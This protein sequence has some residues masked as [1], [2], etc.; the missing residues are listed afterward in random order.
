MDRGGKLRG[1]L[2]KS[3]AG[4]TIASTR[5]VTDNE[6]HHVMLSG[7]SGGQFLYLDGEFIGSLS[8]AIKPIPLSHAYLGGGYVTTPWDGQLAGTKYFAGQIDEAALYTTALGHGS[9]AQNYR[10]RTGLVSGDA[11]TTADPSSATPLPPSGAWTNRRA[12]P[13]PPASS[14]PTA[15]PARTRTPPW[16][17]P[18]SSASTTAPRRSSPAPDRSPCRAT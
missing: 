6:W 2:D 3:Q 16:A 7:Y 15:P 17:P 9:A 14:P 10:A 5:V 1:Q 12:R 8:G 18:A 11:R 4:T 13:G